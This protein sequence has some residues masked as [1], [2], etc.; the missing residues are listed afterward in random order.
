MLEKPILDEELNFVYSNFLVNCLVELQ[1]EFEIGDEWE[2]MAEKICAKA[3]LPDS[4]EVIPNL[5]L[6]PDFVPHVDSVIMSVISIPA[7]TK[8]E[9]KALK[10]RLNHFLAVRT[11]FLP[12]ISIRIS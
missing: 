5:L 12:F 1:G 11:F 10:V 8:F 4:D 6:E 9:K 7:K 2:T 3:V